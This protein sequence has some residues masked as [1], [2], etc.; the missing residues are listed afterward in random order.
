MIAVTAVITL[1]LA[2]TI[3]AGRALPIGYEIAFTV[4]RGLEVDI[5]RMDIGRGLRENLT[6]AS[7]ID[8]AP[9]WSPQ[10]DQLL[11]L[12]NRDGP[13]TIYVMDADGSNIRRLIPLE[14]GAFNS[15]QWSTD[16][17]LILL[18]RGAP[19]NQ[20]FFTVR[21]DGSD[22]HE[23]ELS[24]TE[25]GI[26]RDLDVTLGRPNIMMSPDGVQAAFFAFREGRWGVYLGTKMRQNAR[27]IANVVR[28]DSSPPVWSADGLH[29]VYVAQMIDGIDLYLATPGSANTPIYRLTRDRAIEADVAWRP[30]VQ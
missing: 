1:L 25:G 28:Q 16:G 12:S 26:V 7:S 2:A 13:Y 17:E 11:F 30:N 24:G 19:P 15:M 5:Y 29:I 6:S 8:L 10:G 18:S 9:M 23:I 20:R 3:T 14:Q 27:L 22:F 21:A 4:Y